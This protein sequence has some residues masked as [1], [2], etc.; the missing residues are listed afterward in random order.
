MISHF[1]SGRCR[2]RGSSNRFFSNWKADEPGRRC[3]PP[4]ARP[5]QRGAPLMR[6]GRICLDPT[7]VPLMALLRQSLSELSM[8]FCDMASTSLQFIPGKTPSALRQSASPR[9]SALNLQR[10]ET[11]K[12]LDSG[13]SSPCCHRIASS[14]GERHGS[15]LNSSPSL[16][17]RFAFSRAVGPTRPM[18][19]Y[20][21]AADK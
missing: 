10:E 12:A 13:R 3:P 9:Q 19:D 7:L 1:A 20:P 15:G 5:S 6:Q 11:P 21:L 16:P 18:S 2:K 14:V 17:P 8:R 4:R